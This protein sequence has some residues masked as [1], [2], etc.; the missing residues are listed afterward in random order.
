MTSLHA[1]FGSDANSF[2]FTYE[3]RDGSIAHRAGTDLP[4]SL[5]SFVA[6]A[7][8][9]SQECASSLRVQLG[10]NRSYVA[11]TGS[12]WVA[13]GIPKDLLT[14]LHNT[15]SFSFYDPNGSA[16]KTGT[17]D[18]IAWHDNGSWYFANGGAHTSSLTDRGADILRYAWK[19]LVHASL[20]HADL[21]VRA[22][23]LL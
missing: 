11:W 22:R 20:S 14:A 13:H 8:S 16:L 9:L 18:N 4:Q 21:A 6:R 10:A 3:M 1:S 5:E 12:V 23:L 7:S 17:L 15:S 2:F 19:D